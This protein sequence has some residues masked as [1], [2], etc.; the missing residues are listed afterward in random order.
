LLLQG[1]L[2]GFFAR[3]A[4][5]LEA[6]GC[7]VEKVNFNGGDWIFYPS[8]AHNFRD[9]MSA[10]PAYLDRILAA[11]N[12]DW[13]LLFGDCRPI[14]RVAHELAA[15]HGVAVGV[16]EEGYVRPD[17]ITLEAGGVNAHSS[18]PRQP[19]FYRSLRGGSLPVA[20]PV[21]N[22]FWFMALWAVVYY[23]AAH[24]LKPWFP[25]YEHHRPL[26]I[27]E[28]I[29]WLRG[30]VRKS[31]YRRAE[32]GVEERL[33]RDHAQRYFLVPLQVHNDSQVTVHSDFGAV[34]PFIREV[35]AS[36]GAHAPAGTKLVLKHHPLD[37]P[38]NDY[39]AFIA[40]VARECGVAER[41]LYIHDQHLPSLLEHARGAI[42]INSTVGLQALDHRT[43]L[44]VCG[45]ALYDMPGLTFQGSL[46]AFWT[47]AETFAV[48]DTLFASFKRHL[49]L[50]T[51]LGGSFYR[52]LPSGEAV[53]VLGATTSLAPL[54]APAGVATAAE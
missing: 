29:P 38:Y 28:A 15:K 46:D 1:P 27:G 52:A 33:I 47:G 39:A 24:A 7:V 5:T 13:V 50:Q 4:A 31:V 23:V 14:H 32:A 8:A 43:P 3:F 54:E 41:V 51:Q 17:F 16:F 10:W 9:R 21:G 49:L 45:R 30:M 6:Q 36:F 19:E 35:I 11:G 40:N 48:D 12:F 2:G 42:V 18:L 37:R 25:H 20:T 44:K 22:A 53:E 26:G 34:A